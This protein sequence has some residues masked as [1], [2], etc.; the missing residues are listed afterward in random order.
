MPETLPPLRGSE[1]LSAVHTRWAD[2]HA[3][4]EATAYSVWSRLARR[5][6]RVGSQVTGRGERALLGDLIRAV[7][8][9]AARCDELAARVE[10]LGTNVDDLARTYGE[11][12]TQ[13][14]ADLERLRAHSVDGQP[15][16]EPQDG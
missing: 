10:A 9:V 16:P 8:A 12:I 4:A 1:L 5:A 6:R 2:L 15:G 13:A 14:R 3:G 7:D 11:D